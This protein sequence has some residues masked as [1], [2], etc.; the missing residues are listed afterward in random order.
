MSIEGKLDIQL[1]TAGERVEQ[2]RIRST[3]PVHAAGVFRGKPVAEVQKLLPLLF[4]ICGTAQACASARACERAAGVRTSPYVEA[5]REQL[6]GL[7][8]LR[9][10]LWRILLDWPVFL[11]EEADKGG[12]SGIISLQ[13]EFRQILT[14]GVNPFVDPAKLAYPEQA[15]RQAET[16]DEIEK[17]LERQVFGVPPQRWLE[18]SSLHQLQAW[19]GQHDTV[20]SRLLANLIDKRWA[21]IGGVEVMP[22][23]ALEEHER[24]ELTAGKKFSA[25][26]QWGGQCCETTSL[27]RCRSPLLEQLEAEYSKGLLVRLLARLTE[28]ARLA[29]QL[30]Q[31][32]RQV[33]TETVEPP[34]VSVQNPAI[35][36][37]SAAR[38]QL[39][40]RV[41]VDGD[42]IVDYRITAP[43]EW[44]FHP[45]GVVAR[46]LETLHGSREQLA[47]QARLM[48]NAID[49]CVA[50]EL[51]VN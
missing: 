11:G 3:R 26:P 4:S 7:E 22:L 41:E 24:L 45:R 44:N 33:S 1:Q 37:V 35:G 36:Q 47:Q 18:I 8:T 15:H 25:R 40:H 48:I 16:L 9:E 39:V 19:L 6:V 29:R 31:P 12:M 30:R 34:L 42:T 17:M 27:T 5:V 38:G 46:S 28:M 2:V 20:A 10:H 43:T 32:P 13:Q 23:P 50:F 51:G 21:G 14:D 49:P